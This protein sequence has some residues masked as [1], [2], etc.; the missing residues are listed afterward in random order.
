MRVWAGLPMACW[1]AAC[2]HAN[3][4]CLLP[5]PPFLHA[6]SGILADAPVHHVQLVMA[7]RLESL[8]LGFES[9]LAEWQVAAAARQG[10]EEQLVRA[11]GPGGCYWPDLQAVLMGMHG[12]A[13]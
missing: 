10:A 8:R 7:R 12:L 13:C 2:Q 6:S 3:S 1:H 5:S 11:G 4:M 9:R